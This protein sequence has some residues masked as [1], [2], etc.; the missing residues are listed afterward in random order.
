VGTGTLRNRYYKKGPDQHEKFNC[1]IFARRVPTP[2]TNWRARRNGNFGTAYLMSLGGTND[3]FALAEIAKRY[4]PDASLVGKLVQLQTA[5]FAIKAM[6]FGARD[7]DRL[8]AYGTLF[9]VQKMQ[10]IRKM[11]AEPYRLEIDTFLSKLSDAPELKV[12]ECTFPIDAYNLP[13]Q[14]LMNSDAYK[15]CVRKQ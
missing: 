14:L 11:S 3:P 1:R 6:A 15:T 10:V 5:E 13:F 8:T 2:R 4:P 12:A 7:M 9:G